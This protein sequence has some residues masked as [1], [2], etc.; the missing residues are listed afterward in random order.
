M[1]LYLCICKRP[2]LYLKNRCLHGQE[3][4]W[5]QTTIPVMNLSLV[6]SLFKSMHHQFAKDAAVM[7]KG[8]YRK[9]QFILLHLSTF[10]LPR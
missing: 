4:Y 1:P 7:T 2:C 3:Q 10:T 9:D 8:Q 6:V 5:D